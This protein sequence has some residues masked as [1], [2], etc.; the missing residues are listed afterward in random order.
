MAKPTCWLSWRIWSVS[1]LTWT[2]SEPCIALASWY[3]VLVPTA[4]NKPFIMTA[5]GDVWRAFMYRDGQILR[6]EQSI[7]ALANAAAIYGRFSAETQELGGPP[8]IESLPGFHDLDAVYDT[9]L[10][11][12]DQADGQ[13]SADLSDDIARIE[14][15]KTKI[16]AGCQADGLRW[17][18]DRVVHNDTKLSNV[19]FA[20]D[21]CTATAVLDLDLAMMGPSWHD[22]GDMVRSACWHGPGSAEGPAF[23]LELVQRVLDAYIGAARHSLTDDEIVTFALA[24]PRISLELGIRYLN[25]HLRDRPHLAVAGENGHLHRGRL[26]VN[27]ADKM[28]T[29]YDALRDVVDAHIAR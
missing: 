23:S 20:N 13:R 19:L 7:V 14:A 3:P 12:I 2:G 1:P 11:D 18:A 15:L 8:L 6:G 5:E 27:L 10:R 29:A 22:V 24:G 28:F 4:K 17:R 16:D 25:D 26:N 21:G 9:L